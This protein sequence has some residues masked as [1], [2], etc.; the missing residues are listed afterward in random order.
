MR[1]GSAREGE[2][3]E[4]ERVG[5]LPISTMISSGSLTIVPF[6][7]KESSGRGRRRRSEREERKRLEET[8]T[9]AIIC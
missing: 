6:G 3:R 1:R 9:A 8:T 2:V 7:F 4:R 5:A